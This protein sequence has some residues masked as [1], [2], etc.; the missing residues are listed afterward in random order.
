LNDLAMINP[1]YQFSL[2]W[3]KDLFNKSINDSKEIQS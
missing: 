3:Y 1:M 2:D